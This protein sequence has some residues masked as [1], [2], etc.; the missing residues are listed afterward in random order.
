MKIVIVPDSFKECLSAKDVAG[1]MAHAVSN[2]LPD[3]EI[4]TIPL[5]DGGEGTVDV[6]A[7]A[8]HADI[9]KCTVHDPVGRLIDAAYAFAGDMAII[10]VAQ[11]CGLQL[12]YKSERNPLTASSRGVGELIMDA[13]RN[14][15]RKYIIGLGGTATCDGGAGMLSVS[16]V[17]DVLKECA[18]ELLCDV[19]APFIGPHGAARVF[20]PQKGASPED[21]EVIEKRMKALAEAMRQETGTDVSDIPGAGA[22]GGI[23][24]ALM[25]YS[26]AK[27]SSGAARIMELSGFEK[28]IE[29]ADL[30]ITGE[31]K[32]D[33]QTLMGKV[34]YCVLNKSKGIPVVLMSGRIDDREELISAGFHNLIE[35]SSRD[36]PL[37]EVIR[38]ETALISIKN[39][40]ISFF[41]KNYKIV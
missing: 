34:P 15:V 39:A 36:V 31:G 14:G 13:Y 33:C 38:P 24:G 17:K 20:A 8:L 29:G 22:A 9:C 16:G 23:A 7:G 10:E 35:V 4:I 28:A 5:A 26:R 41:N 32:S 19:T 21:V 37:S 12:L 11:A 2:L 6:L 1:A 40:V 3:A 25:A 30:I 27:V 18:V